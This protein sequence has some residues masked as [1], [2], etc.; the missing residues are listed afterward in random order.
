MILRISVISSASGEGPGAD[1][2]L[3]VFVKEE[4]GCV[5]PAAAGICQLVEKKIIHKAQHVELRLVTIETGVI[6]IGIKAFFKAADL[7][8]NLFVRSPPPWI[9][10]LLLR[11]TGSE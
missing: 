9:T 5:L 1:V 10:T 3:S 8:T 2:E 6:V 4:E 11:P 7:L